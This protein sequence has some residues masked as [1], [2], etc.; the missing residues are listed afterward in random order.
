MD[1]HGKARSTGHP[2]VLCVPRGA[3]GPRDWGEGPNGDSPRPRGHGSRLS[4]GGWAA[5]LGSLQQTR[6]LGPRAPTPRLPPSW[7]RRVQRHGRL[8][9]SQPDDCALRDEGRWAAGPP[10][11]VPAL[12]A[13]CTGV[14][15]WERFL[16]PRGHRSSPPPT[17]PAPR[18]LGS[19]A[20]H[21]T[22]VSHGTPTVSLSLRRTG[23]GR[24]PRRLPAS[25][26]LGTSRVAGG[27]PES[28]SP[29]E[30]SPCSFLFTR[31]P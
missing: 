23:R 15:S 16:A 8:F 24:R 18:P 6:G 1:K 3:R 31:K 13:P 14:G 22:C 11:H 28:H 26:A 21:C 25:A 4:H 17:R 27:R 5:G 7:P 29:R 30:T 20:G 19:P 9:S 12:P 10:G 2:R